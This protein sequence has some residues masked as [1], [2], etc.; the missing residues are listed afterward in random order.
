[1]AILV[2][3]G[4]RSRPKLCKLVCD[5]CHRQAKEAVPGNRAVT[6][7]LPKDWTFRKEKHGKAKFLRLYACNHCSVKVPENTP[8]KT[9]HVVVT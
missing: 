7:W 9:I 1:M 5:F 2:I 6:L 8:P 4:S 3:K